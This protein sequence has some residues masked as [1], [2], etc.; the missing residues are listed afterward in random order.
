MEVKNMSINEGDA[1]KPESR[2][3]KTKC[4]VLDEKEVEIVQVALKVLI[5]TLDGKNDIS[6]ST[7]KALDKRL[8]E[9]SE[10]AFASVHSQGG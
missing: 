9:Y 7:V 2:E 4:F 5:N 1:V 3:L 10:E 6:V 8:W